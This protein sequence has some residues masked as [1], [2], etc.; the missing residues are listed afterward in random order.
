MNL[1]ISLGNI[2]N[3]LDFIIANVFL[4]TGWIIHR[5]EINFRIWIFFFFLFT[6]RNDRNFLKCFFKLIFAVVDHFWN[7]LRLKR[8]RTWSI[9]LFNILRTRI[10]FIVNLFWELDSFHYKL[11]FCH[12]ICLLA[13]ILVHHV[14]C[15]HNSH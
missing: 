8:M 12:F 15:S 14:L 10:N 4:V 7:F 6:S 9:C 3:V 2:V 1:I 13:K 11:C 5:F